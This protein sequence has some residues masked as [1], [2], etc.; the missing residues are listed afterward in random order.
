[1]LA[2]YLDPA[3]GGLPERLTFD[4]ARH[5]N[6]CRVCWFMVTNILREKQL[7]WPTG[8]HEQPPPKA[9]KP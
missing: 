4:V 8:L 7:P 6:Q 1:M 2:S 3:S 9:V 5:V